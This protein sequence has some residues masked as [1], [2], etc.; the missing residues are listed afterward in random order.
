M[1]KSNNPE[2]KWRFLIYDL[3]LSFGFD[4]KSTAS[5]NSLEHATRLGNEW[6][7]CE[8][9]N[10][11]FRSL[12]QNDS[13][14]TQFINR[15]AY[16]LN[17]TFDSNKLINI[18]NEFEELFSD[19]ITEHINRWNYPLNLNQWKEEIDILREFAVDRP[20]YIT[21]YLMS[22]F[23]LKE[24]DFD[25]MSDKIAGENILSMNPNPSNGN[26]FLYNNTMQD[27]NKGS[28]M[29]ISLIGN[30]LYTEKNVFLP[31]KGR[32]NL[33]L[34][35]IPNGSYLLFFKNNDIVEIIKFIIIK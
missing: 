8:C 15:F 18:I 28:V 6:P 5:T 9:S 20:C 23:D 7:Y 34:D 30:V 27:I 13:F 29:I 12:L 22:Y 16:H 26:C 17:Y 2:S 3:D 19:E 14:Q 25:C 21:Q 1:W 32:K 11:I 35:K 31:A 33:Y 4:N 10:L 24:F